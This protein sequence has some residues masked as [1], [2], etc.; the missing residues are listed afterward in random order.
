MSL[1]DGACYDEKNGEVNVMTL[2]DLSIQTAKGE[3]KSLAE[4]RGKVL[5]IVNTAS[6][7]GFTPQYEELQQLY[8]TYKERGFEILAFPSN[9]FM[10]QEPGTNDEIQS[11]CQLNYGVT[12][13]VLKKGDVKGDNAHPVF[14]YLTEKAK[15]AFG[16]K[17]I[18]WNFTKF[19]VS[20]DGEQIKRF[21]PQTKPSAMK[22]DIEKFLNEDSWS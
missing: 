11:F 12:F 15:G 2:Y 21:S 22:E 17:A 20:R 10:N 1:H 18:K 5:L 9:Q 14:Q 6:K 7:C 8:E 3:T 4:Y 16:T 13:P 19:L